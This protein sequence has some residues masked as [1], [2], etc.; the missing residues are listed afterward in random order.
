MGQFSLHPGGLASTDA[1]LKAAKL[2]Q[3]ERVLE[4]GCGPGL[5]THALMLAGVDITVVEPSRRMLEA[6]LRSCLLG[7]G[8]SPAYHHG[9]AEDLSA[10]P[11]GAFD[12]AILEC[13]FGF[14]Q[15]KRRA[16][17]EC[18]RVLSPRRSRICVVDLHYVTPPPESVQKAM[19]EALGK[20]MET[21]MKDDWERYYSDFDLV[22]WET[23]DV[24]PNKLVT[25]DE[26]KHRLWAAGLLNQLPG[27]GEERFT[28]ISN[29]WNRWNEVFSENKRYMK[30]H[31]AVWADR[32]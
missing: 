29:H 9:S 17:N 14:I 32:A 7:T 16:L 8:R 28:R 10:L 22:H 25:P 31:R 27:A 11:A 19:R 3:D 15:D 21:L 20:E 23:F 18:R 26:I 13:V 6:A 24:E 5:T 4:I 30:G 2:R 12:V 1:V